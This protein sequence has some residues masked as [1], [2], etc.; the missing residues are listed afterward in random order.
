VRPKTLEAIV[1]H[2]AD[3]LDGDAQGA[4]DHYERDEEGFGAFTSWS[5]MHE[6]ELYRGEQ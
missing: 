4:I 5:T 3:N 1:L 2:Y 6:G